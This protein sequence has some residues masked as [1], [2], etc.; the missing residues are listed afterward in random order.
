MTVKSFK[1]CALNY[2]NI[3]MSDIM[4]LGLVFRKVVTFNTMVKQTTC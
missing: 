1:E 2:N 3:H 4:H